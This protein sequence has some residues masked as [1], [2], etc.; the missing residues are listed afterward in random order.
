M[1]VG[2]G[3]GAVCV[4]VLWGGGQWGGV[5]T[6]Y[7]YILPQYTVTHTVTYDNLPLLMGGKKD[8]DGNLLSIRCY[9]V[10]YTMFLYLYITP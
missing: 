2:G 10:Q 5:S 8:W 6:F 3:G 7:T 4:C 1:M 9:T